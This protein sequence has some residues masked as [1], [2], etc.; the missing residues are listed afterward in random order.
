M[1]KKK[2]IIGGLIALLVVILGVAASYA[3]FSMNLTNGKNFIISTGNLTLSLDDS[4]N[5]KTDGKI[6]FNG[7]E[8]MSETT[9]MTK[10]PYTFRLSNTGTINSTYTIYLDDLSIQNAPKARLANNLVWVNIKN[11]TNNTSYTYRVSDLIDRVLETGN[12][13][14]NSYNDYELRIWLDYNA[15]NSEQDKYFG[16]KLRIEGVQNN[17]KMLLKNLIL[18][19]NILRTETPDFTG[20]EP[21][22]ESYTDNNFNGTTSNLTMSSTYQASYFT[23]ADSYTFDTT[24]GN[25]TLVNPQV[26]QYSSCYETLKNKYIVLYIGSNTTAAS[27]TNISTIYKVTTDTTL[28]KLYY[29]SSTKTP[30]YD[31]S[32][33]GLYKLSVTN[34]FGGANGDT[35]YFRGDVTNNKVRFANLDW[36]IVR[37][38]EDG[39]VRL[40]LDGSTDESRHAFNS[41]YNDYTYMYYS[42][43]SAKTDVETWYNT[44]ITGDNALKVASGNYFCEAA[45]TKYLSSYTSGSATM[46][47]YSS[48]T[49]DLKC[50]TDG[51]AKGLLNS[52]VGLINYDEVVLAGGYYDKSNSGYYLYQ[53][54]YWWTMSPG[55]FEN[56]AYAWFMCSDGTLL[57]SYVDQPIRLRPVINLKANTEATYDQTTGTYTIE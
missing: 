19:D 10:S 32:L 30:N 33:S 6:I 44:N 46:T 34:G 53:N 43:S 39:T 25:Y 5:V 55:G 42:N 31:S 4:S 13:N 15:G 23:Y 51:N 1:N 45:K 14:A 49:P 24:T 7:L 47:V 56:H 21:R 26:C 36:R 54:Y 29:I 35:Y 20:I 48:Y 17:S 2:V 41:N 38:N 40:I 52:S 28:D 50:Q 11:L 37:I 8:P 3:L 57:N 9:A 27:S 22:A 18:A 12:L 16:I